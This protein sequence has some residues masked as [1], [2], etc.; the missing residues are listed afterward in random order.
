MS[1]LF[2]LNS[3]AEGSSVTKDNSQAWIVIVQVTDLS[4]NAAEA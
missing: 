2:F 3:V 1:F 4:D